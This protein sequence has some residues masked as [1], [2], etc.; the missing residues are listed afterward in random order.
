MRR[1]PGTLL[2]VGHSAV[3]SDLTGAD[4]NLS[5][6]Q[7]LELARVSFNRWRLL[8]TRSHLRPNKYLET[9]RFH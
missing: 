1:Y 9:V 6:I 3:R 4:V 7:H 2:Q 5:R 8:N